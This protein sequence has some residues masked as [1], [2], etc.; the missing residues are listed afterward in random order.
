MHIKCMPLLHINRSY[1][2]PYGRFL[3][4]LKRFTYKVVGTFF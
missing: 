4:H 2:Q 1:K 3:T